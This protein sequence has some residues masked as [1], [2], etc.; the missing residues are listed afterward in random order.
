MPAFRKRLIL[1]FGLVILALLLVGI[2][3]VLTRSKAGDSPDSDTKPAQIEPSYYIV[4]ITNLTEH[5]ASF[6]MEDT[7]S[8]WSSMWQTVNKNVDNDQDY[9]YGNIRENSIKESVA[10]SGLP[11]IEML[12][13]LPDIQ[14]SFKLTI[15]GSAESEYQSAFITCPQPTEL[16][17]PATNC[18]GQDTE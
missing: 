3:L 13:D 18:I 14:R 17:Y 8:I 4:N 10:A 7:Y 15:E 2:A 6:P 9:Y 12:I 16:V 5:T 11:V 1:I